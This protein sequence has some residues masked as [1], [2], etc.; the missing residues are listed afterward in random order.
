[1]KILNGL[2]ATEGSRLGYREAGNAALIQP[3][4]AAGEILQSAPNCLRS[5]GFG[6][7]PPSGNQPVK[8]IVKN[9]R[10]N[11]AVRLILERTQRYFDV[12]TD[13]DDGFR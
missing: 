10:R 9:I 3:Q 11:R 5:S 13:R 7:A 4:G 2:R 1:V 6:A 12:R 8:L